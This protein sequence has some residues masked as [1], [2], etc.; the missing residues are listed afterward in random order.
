VDPGEVRALLEAER[1]GLLAH[2]G[3]ITKVPTDPMGSVSF[4]KR[5]GDGTAHAVE[6]ITAVDAAK[7]LDAKRGDVERALE[8]LDEGTY[9][10]CDTCGV[11]VGDERL[12]AMPWAVRCIGCAR[13]SA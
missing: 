4:G 3:E 1:D 11:P 8:K 2:L 12:E 7:K 9:G 5:V 13:S 10:V 6:R